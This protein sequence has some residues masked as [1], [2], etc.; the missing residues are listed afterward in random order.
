MSVDFSSPSPDQ[1]PVRSRR[2]AHAGIKDGYP[3]KM[4]YFS[5]VGLSGVKTVADRHRRAVYHNK[6]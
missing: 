4:V 6:H 3:F 1:G 2:S 5:A